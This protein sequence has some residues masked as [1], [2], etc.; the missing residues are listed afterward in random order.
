[1]ESCNFHKKGNNEARK[2]DKAIRSE[3]KE[4]LV[5]VHHLFAN[6]L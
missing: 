3:K 1:M 6:Y 4:L 2:I 5:L